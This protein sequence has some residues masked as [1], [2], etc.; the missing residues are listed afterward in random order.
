MVL[1]AGDSQLLGCVSRQGV[2]SSST[3]TRDPG[4]GRPYEVANGIDIQFTLCEHC[5]L[6][7]TGEEVRAGPDCETH[8][9]TA[10][11]GHA[12]TQ[13]EEQRG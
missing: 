7:L 6:E 10:G 5:A 4:G 11:V 12:A 8:S 9:S 2:M 3:K 13:S 1:P